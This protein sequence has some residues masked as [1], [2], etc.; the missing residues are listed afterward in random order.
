MLNPLESTKT[1]KS[2]PSPLPFLSLLLS[3][4]SSAPHRKQLP[5]SPH[6]NM[7]TAEYSIT[8]QTTPLLLP[9]LLPVDTPD[10]QQMASVQPRI[11]STGPG[12]LCYMD[13]PRCHTHSSRR[14]LAAYQGKWKHTLL[15]TPLLGRR[16]GGTSQLWLDS[17]LRA[18]FEI[19]H[20]NSAGD[21]QMRECDAR[22]HILNLRTGFFFLTCSLWKTLLALWRKFDVGSYWDEHCVLAYK[23]RVIMSCLLTQGPATNLTTTL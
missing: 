22:V 9:F 20:L 1:W 4:S 7:N 3:L 15:H 5:D 23:H 11:P 10:T 21:I 8:E 18:M 2:P 13:L 14:Q 16:G 6:H 17:W 12:L 19:F